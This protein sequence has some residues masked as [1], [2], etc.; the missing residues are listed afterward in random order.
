M[1]SLYAELDRNYDGFYT[2]RK[3]LEIAMDHRNAN[4]M[5]KLSLDLG[6]NFQ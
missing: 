2:C 1:L 6:M 5:L 3:A 4:D